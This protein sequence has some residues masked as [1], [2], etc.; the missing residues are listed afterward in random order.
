M[1]MTAC[2]DCGQPSSATRCPDCAAGRPTYDSAWN[3]L[4]IRARKAQPFCSDCSTTHDLTTDHTPAAWQRKAAGKP[5]RLRDVQV[6]C[7][8]HNSQKGPAR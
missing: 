3:R 5:I 2:L 4:S 7:R 6:L 8:R 1:T